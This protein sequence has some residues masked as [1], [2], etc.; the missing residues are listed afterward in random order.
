MK[1]SRRIAFIVLLL[2]SL[3]TLGQESSEN[4]SEKKLAVRGYIKD[5]L[6]FTFR[7]GTDSTLIDNLVHNRVNFEW[8]LSK[9]VTGKL[10]IRNRI[11]SGDLV[12]N[13]PGYADLI[14]INNDHFDLS[15]TADGDKVIL[16]SMIDRAYLKWSEEKWELSIGR[17][18]INWGVNVAWNPNDI[19]NAYSLLDFD[20]EE[21][22]GSDA[23][24]YQRYIGFAGG[25]EFAVKMA[26]RW[27][28][29]TAAGLYKWN[30]KSY[31]FQ[32]M[33]GVMQN[34]LVLGGAWAGNVGLTGF[35]GEVTFL[36]DLSQD[37]TTDFLASLSSDYAFT[38]SL[39]LNGS[40][41]YNSAVN[42]LSAPSFGS[43]P[44][45]LDVRSI[46]TTKWSSYL[47]ASYPFHP[48]LS[49]S[50]MMLFFPG[51]SG[52][53]LSPTFSYSPITNLDLDVIGQLFF[54]KEQSNVYLLYTRVRY[55][56]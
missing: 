8:F 5:L 3:V 17:Q 4:E 51:D 22:P 2:Q 28:E 48:L 33:G 11:F 56:F 38:N 39:Y 30:R 1:P 36:E 12:K 41:L 49:G 20:Y 26:D 27:E 53:L 10:E 43:S 50:L 52:Q 29:L 13:I 47:L 25:Y 40:V 23:I 42:D 54:D 31:D 9:K 37:G 24:R 14:D 34:N 46:S 6:T 35:K 44:A 55:S 19:F 32:V 15:V 45:N 16:H 18:R 7:E 21:R